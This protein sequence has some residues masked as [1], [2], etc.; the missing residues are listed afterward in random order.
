MTT[1]PQSGA[2]QARR[3]EYY[4]RIR[5]QS[6]APL[7]ERYHGLL[8]PE[9]VIK[10]Q[11][12]IWPYAEVRASLLEAANVITAKEAERRV[13]MLENPAF[14]GECKALEG[15]GSLESHLADS[16]QCKCRSRIRAME[17]PL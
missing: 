14:E 9:P 10:A 3:Q 4:G 6:L 8:T 1:A 11:P 16:M 17:Q 15:D 2:T 12:F 5:T 7:W 13:L